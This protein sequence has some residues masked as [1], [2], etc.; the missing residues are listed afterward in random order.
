MSVSCSSI[1]ALRACVAAL[2]LNS[3]RSRYLAQRCLAWLHSSLARFTKAVHKLHASGLVYF[4]QAALH[5]MICGLAGIGC[6]GLAG[7]LYGQFLAHQ[8]HEALTAAN[9]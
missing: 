6:C 4:W 5:M 7:R 1:G 2:G 3:A 9:T 8:N